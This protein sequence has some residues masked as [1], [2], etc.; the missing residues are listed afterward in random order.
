MNCRRF[1]NRFYEYVE[2]SLSDD[3]QAAANEHLA[4][5]SACRQAVAQEQQRA[6][7]LFDRLRQDTETLALR[8]EVRR[9]IL[10]SPKCKS[11]PR[12]SLESIIG[13][14]NRF[15]RSATIA[16][17]LLLFAAFLLISHLS[18]TRIRETIHE[19]E[20]APGDDRNLQPAI[21]I[22]ISYRVPTFKFRRE[23]NLVVDTLSYETVVASGTL[24]PGGQEPVPQEQATKTPL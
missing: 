20:T 16:V 10:T 19:T 11:V 24:R 8:P 13:L 9:R 6:Q 1:Q 21:S 23:G 15:A 2:G 12:A 22:Q 4:R 5:C 3:T 7:F 18:G 17:S 14:W